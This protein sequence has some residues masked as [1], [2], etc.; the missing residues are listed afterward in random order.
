MLTREANP[1]SQRSLPSN[2]DRPSG[3]L[4]CRCY[5]AKLVIL[6]GCLPGF[7]SSSNTATLVYSRILGQ[8]LARFSLHRSSW[9]RLR[10]FFGCVTLLVRMEPMKNRRALK[11]RF[12]R[13][14][15]PPGEKIKRPRDSWIL[16]N[17]DPWTNVPPAFGGFANLLNIRVLLRHLTVSATVCSVQSQERI[18]T[19][20]ALLRWKKRR[21]L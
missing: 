6:Y 10:P 16:V 12:A 19:L 8:E 13:S 14:L 20:T 1:D 11:L 5:S 18:G 4:N 9:K 7:A 15:Y 2:T 17:R 3:H 21:S